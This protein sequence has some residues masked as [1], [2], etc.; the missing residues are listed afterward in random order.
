MFGRPCRWPRNDS[1]SAPLPKGDAWATR[2]G[3]TRVRS[4]TRSTP[5]RRSWSPEKARTATGTSWT[6]SVRR[7]AVTTTSPISEAPLARASVGDWV[8]AAA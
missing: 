7:R 5:E 8:W 2:P 3:A 4:L 1:V 6:N